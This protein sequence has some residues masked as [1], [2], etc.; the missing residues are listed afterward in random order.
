MIRKPVVLVILDGFG[1]REQKKGNAIAAAHKPFFENILKKY[2]HIFIQASG[3]FVG[4]LPGQMGNSE[5]GHLTIGAG[6]RI[7]SDLVRIN[8]SIADASFFSNKIALNELK[9]LSN[10]NTLHIIGLVSNGGVHSSMDHL[11]ALLKMAKNHANARVIIHAILDGRDVPRRSAQSY[12]NQLDIFINKNDIGTIGSLHGRFYAMDRDNNWDRTKASYD[13]LTKNQEM[14]FDSW[15]AA[16]DYY[17][18]ENITD[19]FIPPTQLINMKTIKAGDGVLFFNFRPDRARQLTEAFS[20][21]PFK[22]FEREKIDLSFFLTMTQYDKKFNVPFIIPPLKITHTLKEILSDHGKNIFAIAETEKYA[23]VTYFFNGLKEE[24]VQHE[25]RLL[26]PSL[27]NRNYAD[28]PC[29]SA[30]KITHKVIEELKKNAYDFYLIN[31]ANADMVGHT[32]NFNATVKA[33]ECIDEQLKKLWDEIK[34]V[35]GVLCITGDHG[36]AEQMINPETADVQTAHTANPVYFVVMNADNKKP[37]ISSIKELA[38]IAPWIL[39]QMNI[40][41]PHEMQK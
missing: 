40:M 39:Q 31:Y 38:D 17:Y 33:I 27:G 10:D 21:G 20:A 4:L 29:M 41:L 28:A 36:K 19:E 24:P 9:K 6:R 11:N 7:P 26:I 22:H 1:Y 25:M 3:E 18:A 13:A 37:D 5:V 8:K 23:H 32:G 12:L 2:P 35:N 14:K 16:L 30:P 15:Q 34:K